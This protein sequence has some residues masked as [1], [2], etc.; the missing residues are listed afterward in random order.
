[1]VKVKQKSGRMIVSCA[2]VRLVDDAFVKRAH[3]LHQAF[4]KILTQRHE[5][6][7]SQR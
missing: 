7:E 1:M 3:L 4:V 5:G 2:P 6:A